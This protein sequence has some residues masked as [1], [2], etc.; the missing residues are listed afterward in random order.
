M[1]RF[2]GKRN[3]IR[4]RCYDLTY[5]VLKPSTSAIC[6]KYTGY[7]LTYKVLKHLN[8]SWVYPFSKV[9]TWH[10]R[11]WNFH[12]I[13]F[14]HALYRVMTWHIRYWNGIASNGMAVNVPVMTWHIR[15]WNSFPISDASIIQLGYDL[16]YKVLKPAND[17]RLAVCV[18][19]Y[20]LTY[21]V[22]KLLSCISVIKNL[23][24]LWPDI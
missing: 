20:D 15:Y 11:Y 8:F 17:K 2:N 5:K 19:S 23:L 6:V 21:K 22:L 24:T 10:I 16:T 3:H 18:L 13:F 9:M 4:L 14:F 12:P 7:D 1:K